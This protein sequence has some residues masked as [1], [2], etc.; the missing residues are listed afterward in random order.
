MTTFW[1]VCWSC[2]LDCMT[3]ASAGERDVR[4]RRPKPLVTWR[5]NQVANALLLGNPLTQTEPI[6][7]EHEGNKAGLPPGIG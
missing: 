4:C 6:F 3:N 2:S 1:G 7:W 5:A